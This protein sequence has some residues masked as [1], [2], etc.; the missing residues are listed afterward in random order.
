MTLGDGELL[1]A[2]ERC[3][4]P[5]QQWSHCA[6]VRVA[7]LYV[8]RYG[9]EEAEERMR[10]GIKAYNAATQTPEGLDRGYHETITVAF[11]RLIAEAA[12]GGERYESSLEFCDRHPELMDKRVLSRF[13]SGARLMS[14]GA[15]EG[16]V[17]PDL[18]ALPRPESLWGG[19]REGLC[20]G[21][22][23]GEVLGEKNVDSGAV[24]KNR[25]EQ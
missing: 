20:E 2:F 22:R 19:K 1:E 21:V 4:L 23:K 15:K 7:F 18:A 17:E 10:R 3:A 8:F 25:A 24:D 16:F 9:W 14:W 11:L 13:Y 6:H 12:G 5:R